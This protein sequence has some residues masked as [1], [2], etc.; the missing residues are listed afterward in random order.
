LTSIN[1]FPHH[2][3]TTYPRPDEPGLNILTGIIK[4]F[5]SHGG[6]SNSEKFRWEDHFKLKRVTVAFRIWDIASK[7]KKTKRRMRKPQKMKSDPDGRRQVLF[8][9]VRG[10][11][12]VRIPVA[13]DFDYRW[14]DKVA[15]DLEEFLD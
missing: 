6:G 2:S 3:W 1:C 14:V 11:I 7:F 12:P 15:K 8:R 9:D 5:L 10:N 13:Y 4:G